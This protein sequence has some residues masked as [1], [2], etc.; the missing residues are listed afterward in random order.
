M[1]LRYRFLGIPGTIDELAEHASKKGDGHVDIVVF[2]DVERTR[3]GE[4]QSHYQAV[5]KSN[6]GHLTL[7]TERI[8]LPRVSDPLVE[9]YIND[10][11]VSRVLAQG[12]R[13]ADYLA[14]KGLDVSVYNLAQF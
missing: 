6:G 12:K 13:H 11:A 8:P 1:T 5:A 14:T 2:G 10:D 4:R 3:N 7:A 9:W